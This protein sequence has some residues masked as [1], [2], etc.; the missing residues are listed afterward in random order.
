[1]KITEEKNYDIIFLG[2]AKNVFNTIGNFFKSCEATYKRGLKVC[3]IIGENGSSDNTRK[4]LEN[5]K[6]D[7]LSFYFIK[8]DFL[9]SYKNRIVRL[10]HGREFLRKYIIKN[11]ISSKYVSVIDLDTVIAKGFNIDEYLKTIEILEKNK[12]NLFAVSSKSKPY[13][14]D[15]LPLI[16]KDYFEHDV[17]KIQTAFN[18]LN[19][20]KVR[21]NFV[22]QFQEKVTKMR[23]VL[24]LSSHNGLT[25]YYYKY[26]INGSYLSN[27]KDTIKSEHI[28][29]NLSIHNKTN[30]Y[31]LMT[32]KLNLLTPPEHMPL[33]LFEFVKR[34]LFKYLLLKLK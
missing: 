30:K 3:V 29:F 25:T 4:F 17:Y 11:K 24:T 20:Y 14:Y 22:Y 16:I 21:K 33:K 18:P 32:N 12:Q 27:E 31:I 15:M 19:F 5:L 28:N 26:F 23:D 2:L 34:T 8:T 9:D 13:Y 6:I 7:N 10:T 1:M